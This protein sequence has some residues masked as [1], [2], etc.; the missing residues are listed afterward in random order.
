[1][2]VNGST[3]KPQSFRTR[4]KAAIAKV[5]PSSSRLDVVCNLPKVEAWR[6]KYVPKNCPTFD[7]RTQLYDHIQNNVLEAGAI[8]YLEF[9]VSKGHSLRWWSAHATHPATRFF[10]LP[11]GSLAAGGLAGA[12][13]LR[14]GRL[15]RAV[16]PP[17]RAARASIRADA[18]S[19]VMV[20]GVLSPG[21][22]ALTPSWLT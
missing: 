22:L 1:M 19:S 15:R 11:A 17:P 13:C 18:S 9:G 6:K 8:D 21:R 4:I 14:A 7:E 12:A 3:A 16:E 5:M 20:S 10:G 2:S